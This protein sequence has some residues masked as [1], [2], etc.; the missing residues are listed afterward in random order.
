MDKDK[1][2]FIKQPSSNGYVSS[3]I[4]KLSLTSNLP[5]IYDFLVLFEIIF[6]CIFFFYSLKMEDEQWVDDTPVIMV[7]QLVMLGFL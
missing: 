7:R 1:L 6:H 2:L 4:L 3:T 5:W